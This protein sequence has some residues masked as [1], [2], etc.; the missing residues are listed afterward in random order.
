[1]AIS[2][3]ASAA[4]HVRRCLGDRTKQAVGIRLGVRSSGCS[5]L[6][7]VVE[8]AN[9]LQDGDLTFDSHGVTVVTDPKSLVHMEGM[10]VD[11]VREG[12][13]E[14]LKFNNPNVKDS[15]G[16]GESFTT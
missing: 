5:G 8:Y 14:G 7:Y 4:E 1:M 2:L 9:S 12:L 3:T 16:C 10:E 11:Y 6:A 13:Q 15:C